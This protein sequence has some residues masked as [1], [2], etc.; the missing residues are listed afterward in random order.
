MRKCGNFGKSIEEKKVGTVYCSPECRPSF[1][2]SL[3]RTTGLSPGK[4][5]AIS[6]LIVCADLIRRGFE[7]FR[8]VSQDCSSDLVVLKDGKIERVEVKT[9]RSN[10]LPRNRFDI[11][12]QVVDG[13][14]M[15]EPPLDQPT[16]IAA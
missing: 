15:Y 16:A 8:S 3:R 1:Y 9:G 10:K 14:P 2:T 5:G 7:V 4:V 12:A 13:V 11:L 6:E